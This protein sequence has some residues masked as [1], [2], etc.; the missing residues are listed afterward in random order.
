MIATALALPFDHIDVGGT[1][2]FV[3]TA[4]VL[5]GIFK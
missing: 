4:I 2:A 5:I 3:L 1:L